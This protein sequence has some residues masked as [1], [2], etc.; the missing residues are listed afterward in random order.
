MSLQQCKLTRAVD[1]KMF[2]AIRGPKRRSKRHKVTLSRYRPKVAYRVGRGI[3]LLFLDLDARRGWVVSTTPRPLHPRERP[4]THCTGGWLGLRAGLDVCEKSRPPTGFD[5]RTV[6]PVAQSLY[7]LSYPAHG[8][9]HL[10]HKIFLNYK[11]KVVP[12]QAW[13]GSEGSR[14]LRLPDFKTIGT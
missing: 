9:R 7:R 10:P 1:L 12:L 6:Q 5:T 13:T 3:A 2:C 8:Q 11:G 4:G 14:R